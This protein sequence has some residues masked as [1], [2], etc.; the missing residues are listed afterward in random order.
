MPRPFTPAN[1]AGGGFFGFKFRNLAPSLAWSSKSW[2]QQITIIK[3]GW[4]RPKMAPNGARLDFSRR[5]PHPFKKVTV[6]FG[7]SLRT[8]INFFT[9]LQV[10][11]YSIHKHKTSLQSEVAIPVYE[12]SLRVH[13][14]SFISP[15]HYLGKIAECLPDRKSGKSKS[16][17]ARNFKEK[18][19]VDKTTLHTCFLTGWQKDMDSSHF[20][21]F[22]LTATS[23][24]ST[25][26]RSQ[27]CAIFCLNFYEIKIA[28]IS[29]K[30][31]VKC[32]EQDPESSPK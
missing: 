32:R 9:E 10:L 30:P 7:N 12:N 3:D 16:N 11:N 14:L 27:Q 28:T 20:H 18:Q 31:L 15:D 8:R 17:Y 21:L 19:R 23:R 1:L 29:G 26:F 13:Y 25:T 6:F 22:I 24:L 5:H 2:L 4:I